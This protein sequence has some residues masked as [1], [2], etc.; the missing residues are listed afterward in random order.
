M[1]VK[2]MK[3]KRT[4]YIIGIFVLVSTIIATVGIGLLARP[5][6]MYPDEAFLFMGIDDPPAYVSRGRIDL[7]V[8]FIDRDS[9]IEAVQFPRDGLVYFREDVYKRDAALLEA[10]NGE[11]KVRKQDKKTGLGVS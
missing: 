5:P 7:M 2:S 1:T 4:D 8:L 9:H 6:R 3:L 10:L 11:F